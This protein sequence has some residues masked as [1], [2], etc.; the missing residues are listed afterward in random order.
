M[1]CQQSKGS[2]LS[3]RTLFSHRSTHCKLLFLGFLQNP[4]IWRDFGGGCL[5]KNQEFFPFHIAT[6]ITSNT[7][8]LKPPMD[9]SKHVLQSVSFHEEHL[10]A[11]IAEDLKS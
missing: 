2:I 3:G 5:K 4:V 10:V 6:K 8:A 1:C 9:R 11:K 7:R